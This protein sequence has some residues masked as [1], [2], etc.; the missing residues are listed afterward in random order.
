M[1]AHALNRGGNSV[2]YKY[3]AP[4]NGILRIHTFSS[5][6]NTLLA[7]YQGTNIN[8]LNLVAAND[9]YEENGSFGFHSN[10]R[11]GAKTGDVFYIAVDGFYDSSVDGFNTGTIKL[12]YFFENVAA[13]DNFANAISLPLPGKQITTTANVGASKESG[14]TESRRKCRRKIGLV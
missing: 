12:N 7:V 1:P 8:N 9:N 3:V 14:R 4:G 11:V 6:F 5:S 2:W 10:V 13:N